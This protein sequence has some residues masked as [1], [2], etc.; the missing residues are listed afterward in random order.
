MIR[1]PTERVRAYCTYCSAINS[2]QT[3]YLTNM[4][5]EFSGN[6]SFFSWKKPKRMISLSFTNIT[7]FSLS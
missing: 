7:Y 6:H 5:I 4:Y 1:R 3:V 2:T